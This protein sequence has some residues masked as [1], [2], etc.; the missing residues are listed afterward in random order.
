[1]LQEFTKERAVALKHAVAKRSSLEP[2]TPVEYDKGK[3]EALTEALAF[4]HSRSEYFAT[5]SLPSRRLSVA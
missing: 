5:Y 4:A 3:K 2:A 1:M